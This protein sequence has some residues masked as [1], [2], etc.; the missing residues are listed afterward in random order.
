MTRDKELIRRQAESLVNA[1]IAAGFG[2]A[3]AAAK[4]GGIVQTTYNNYERGKTP[5]PHR[6]EEFAKLFRV[7]AR[8]LL[9][10]SIKPARVVKIR[11][12]ITIIGDPS[13]KIDLDKLKFVIGH[14]ETLD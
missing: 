7:S 11:M 2:T 5:F 14:I 1:R 13:Q 10:G 12:S 3:T 6:A 4:A 9:H 8:D